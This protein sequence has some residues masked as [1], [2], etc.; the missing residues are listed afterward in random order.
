V[1]PG[2]SRPA[3]ENI[4]G[5]RFL[6]VELVYGHVNPPAA[7]GD[8]FVFE[9]QPL[10]HPRGSAQLDMAPSAYHAMP[11]NGSVRRA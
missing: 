1:R 10:F 7:K 9:P 11:G 3:L 5:I 6:E 8:A 4:L 2:E